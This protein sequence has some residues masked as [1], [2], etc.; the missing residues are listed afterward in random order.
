MK[1]SAR[2]AHKVIDLWKSL[3]EYPSATRWAASVAVAGL[4][5][6]E[7]DV[8]S[9]SSH[10]SEQARIEVP[11]GP[12]AV[13]IGPATNRTPLQQLRAFATPAARR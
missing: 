6:P 9:V 2:L 11:E 8:I 7:S 12:W 4:A 3:P 5:E 13:D 10:I 1:P